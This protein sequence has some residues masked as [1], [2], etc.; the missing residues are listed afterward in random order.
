VTTLYPEAARIASEAAQP[1]IR[2]S[3]MDDMLF[4]FFFL[5]IAGGVFFFGAKPQKN[6]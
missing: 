3:S 6:G 2:Y 4:P 1:T 5:K